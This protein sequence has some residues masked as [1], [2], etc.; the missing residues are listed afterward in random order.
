MHNSNGHGYNTNNLGI[1]KCMGFTSNMQNPRNDIEENQIS[2]IH[3]TIEGHFMTSNLKLERPEKT[4]KQKNP[5]S[6]HQQQQ[7]GYYYKYQQNKYI[8][9]ISIVFIL[10]P[11]PNS[12]SSV[13]EVRNCLHLSLF[14][15]TASELCNNTSFNERYQHLQHDYHESHSRSF[16]SVD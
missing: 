6:K 4:S 14:Y 12:L 3:R 2:I 11:Q 10:Q 1:S 5:A 15:S 9:K 13:R 16:S 7:Q 8:P